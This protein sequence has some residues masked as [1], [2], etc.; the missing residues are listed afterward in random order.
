MFESIKFYSCKNVC[1]CVCVRFIG[2][3]SV[4]AGEPC[5]LTDDP[6]WIIDPIDG[7]TNFVHAW[8][9]FLNY[10]IS[11]WP[12]EAVVMK[13]TMT[14]S[15]FKVSLHSNQHVHFVCCLWFCVVLI[16]NM[17]LLFWSTHTLETT[18]RHEFEGV[19]DCWYS[20]PETENRV[21]LPQNEPY[22]HG[23]SAV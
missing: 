21:S 11:S 22:I 20:T 5:V 17:T 6:T 19:S 16:W 18:S 9:F 4:A 3:E 23:G 12:V 15:P 1:V 14:S 2:E 10:V 7:T 8:V 13:H